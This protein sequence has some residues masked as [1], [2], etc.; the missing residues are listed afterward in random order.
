MRVFIGEGKSEPGGS[1]GSCCIE[2]HFLK[3]RSNL[4]GSKIPYEDILKVCVVLDH[5]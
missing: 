3:S 2:G 1:Y 4:S 5:V